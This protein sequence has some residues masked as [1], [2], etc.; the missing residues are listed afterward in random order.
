MTFTIPANSPKAAPAAAF[1]RELV[2]AVT[3]RAV[4]LKELERAT[5]VGH[6]SL[7]N[8]R[9]GLILPKTEVALTLAATLDWPRLREIVLEARTRT[10]HRRACPRSFRNE[11][12]NRKIY[13]SEMCRRIAENERVTSRRLRQA[14]QTGSERPA[15]NAVERMRSGLAIAEDRSQM[16][17][18]AIGAMCVGCEPEGICRTADCPLRPFSPLPLGRHDVGEARTGFQ[19]RSDSW[20]PA[21]RERLSATTAAAWADGRI[22]ALPAGSARHPGN[23][24]ERREGWIQRQRDGHKNRRRRPLTP[25]HRAAIAAGHARRR[26]RQELPA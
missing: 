7:D 21:R 26:E 13:C 20:T 18:Q 8:Y 19:V 1:G 10:C 14:G 23:D 22:R 5:G 17:A 25:E 11:G 2:K 15:R 3:V 16:L 12:G 6:T 24:P 4:P 9:R